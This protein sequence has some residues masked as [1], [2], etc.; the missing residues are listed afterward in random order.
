MELSRCSDADDFLGRAGDFLA[1][2]EAEHNLILGLSGRLQADP[3]VYGGEDPYF[4]LVEEGRQVVAAT[5]RTPP[6]N[7]ILS[8]VDDEGALALIAADVHSRFT[9]LPGVLAPTVAAERFAELWEAETG[10]RGRRMLSQ[11][12]FRADSVTLPEGVPGGM[13]D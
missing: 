13:R 5:M 11:R 6:H 9:E 4:A 3:H 8:E 7:L 12:A 2:R 10:A 1:A